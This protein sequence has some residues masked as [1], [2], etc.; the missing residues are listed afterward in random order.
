MKIINELR[1]LSDSLGV[2]LGLEP[3]DWDDIYNTCTDEELEA[4]A[5]YELELERKNAYEI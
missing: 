2:A 4:M 5:K 3:T 1:E